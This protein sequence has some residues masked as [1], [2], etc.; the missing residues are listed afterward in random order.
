METIASEV[1]LMFLR[2]MRD[3]IV[4]LQDRADVLEKAELF[5]AE[6]KTRLNIVRE[7]L[8]DAL[9]RVEQLGGDS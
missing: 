6:L 9:V 7:S 3:E 1:R 8:H 2:I 5:D 4:V